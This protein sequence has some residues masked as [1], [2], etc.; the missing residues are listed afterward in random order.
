MFTWLVLHTYFMAS[1]DDFNVTAILEKLNDSP[2]NEVY[3][4]TEQ[5]NKQVYENS[6]FPIVYQSTYFS[7]LLMTILS[8]P[9]RGRSMGPRDSQ[10]FLPI[11]T[12]FHLPTLYLDSQWYQQK[13]KSPK[14]YILNPAWLTT[15]NLRKAYEISFSLFFFYNTIWALIALS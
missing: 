15:D 10:V 14:I 13:K 11:N 7:V 2:G 6:K 1:G 12:A 3:W 8:L 5:P 9:G 4:V